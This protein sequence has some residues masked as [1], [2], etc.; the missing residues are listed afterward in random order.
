MEIYSVAQ[1]YPAANG[2]RIIRPIDRSCWL[3]VSPCKR[4]RSLFFTRRAAEL[5]AVDKSSRKLP[6]Y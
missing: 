3:L 4:Y 2:H 1:S 5:A 6:T